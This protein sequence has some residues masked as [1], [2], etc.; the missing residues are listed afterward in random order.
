[1]LANLETALTTGTKK[2]EGKVFNY[3]SHVENV[4]VLLEAGMGGAERRGYVSLANNH[5]LDWGVE[6]LV[7]D[8]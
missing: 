4:R 7:T 3:R 1:M 8:G 6:G 5:V 2:W